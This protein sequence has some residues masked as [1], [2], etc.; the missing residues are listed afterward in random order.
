MDKRFLI[1]C[2]LLPLATSLSAQ[3][4][5][6]IVCPLENGMGREAKDAYYWDPP[7]HKVII[8]STTDTVVRS[9]VPGEVVA[10][11]VNEDNKYEVVIFYKDH[12]FWYNNVTRPFVRKM[13]KVT[14]SQ[15]IGSYTHGDELEL[16]VYKEPKRADPEMIDPREMLECFPPGDQPKKGF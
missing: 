12:Y 5:I 3:E 14:P 1:F 2:S 11:Q 7:E 13:Q 8:L 15:A 9:G 16:R 10:V 6:T 4:K